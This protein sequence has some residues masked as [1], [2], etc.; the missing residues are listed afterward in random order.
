M[1]YVLIVIL[2][3]SRLLQ[4]RDNVAYEV[5]FHSNF[6]YDPFTTTKRNVVYLRLSQRRD[7]VVY[8]RSRNVVYLHSPQRR[9]M[10]YISVHH[11]ENIM[12]YIFVC[13]NEETMW[14]NLT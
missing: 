1:R 3:Y 5:R 2:G 9:E 8:L 12:W 14:F 11:N 4:R 7:N 6:R 13:H 10:W